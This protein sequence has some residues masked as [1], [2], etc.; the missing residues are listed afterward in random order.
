[1]CA[2]FASWSGFSLF[3][4]RPLFTVRLPEFVFGFVEAA[5]AFAF[6][7]R[8][9]DILENTPSSTLSAKKP[10]PTLRAISLAESPRTTP[11]AVR[12]AA[13]P[14][15]LIAYFPA[16]L[17]TLLASFTYNIHYT[18]TKGALK[19]PF[20]SMLMYLPSYRPSS[21]HSAPIPAPYDAILHRSPQDPCNPRST[22]K[23]SFSFLPTDP[24]HPALPAYCPPPLL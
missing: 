2:P 12:A 4:A 24:S 7:V 22:H 14:A 5:L 9:L 19:A 13:P 21:R 8:I 11:T 6:C 18:K 23:T 3:F 10:T 20:L 16:A 17:V 1:M 15:L